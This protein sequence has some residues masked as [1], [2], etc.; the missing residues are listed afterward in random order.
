MPFRVHF[1][2]LLTDLCQS[3]AGEGGA[4]V[5]APV[6]LSPRKAMARALKMA[7]VIAMRLDRGEPRVDP[8]RMKLWQW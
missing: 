6:E 1:G 2:T 5:L 4:G 3:D 8:Y 7:G